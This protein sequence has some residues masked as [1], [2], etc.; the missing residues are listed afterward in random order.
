MIETIDVGDLS[1]EVRRSTRRRTVGLTVD[2]GGELVAHA[3]TDLSVE[4]LKDWISRKLLWVH[5]KLAIKASVI[6]KESAPEFV[7]GESMLYLGRRYALRVVRSQGAALRFD[8]RNFLLRRGDRRQAVEH[9]RQWYS[10]AGTQWLRERV[11]FLSRRTQTVPAGV[12]V[13][14]L[15]FRWGSC[16]KADVLYFDWRL[17]Q[18]R[19]RLI[20]Y[21]VIH[22][23]AHLRHRQHDPA[24]WRMVERALPDWKERKEELA[25]QTVQF[26]NVRTVGDR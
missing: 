10:R 1:F 14:D 24:F 12:E 20:D 21:V 5:R 22:E 16:G 7:S 18:L 26:L 25:T 11:E 9:F 23:L 3:P 4:K 19:V 8:G 13:R 17:L 15:G 2:R 6:D